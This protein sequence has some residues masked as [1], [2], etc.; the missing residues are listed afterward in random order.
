[1]K[2]LIIKM[3]K[4]PIEI[5]KDMIKKHRFKKFIAQLKEFSGIFAFSD[6]SFKYSF[7]DDKALTISAF[8][9]NDYIFSIRYTELME[10]DEIDQKVV[11]FLNRY[12]NQLIIN[13]NIEPTEVDCEV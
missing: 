12:S 4:R 6:F 9:G 3:F 13:N 2:N 1:M 7:G 8:D 11:D 5:I 10:N